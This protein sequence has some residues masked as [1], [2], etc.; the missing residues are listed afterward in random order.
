MPFSTARMHLCMALVAIPLVFLVLLHAHTSQNL[1]HI[2][3]GQAPSFLLGSSSVRCPQLHDTDIPGPSGHV[4]QQCYN[5]PS[6]ARNFALELCHAPRE[7]N[8]FALHIARTDTSQC[9]EMETREGAL[10]ADHTL[11]AMIRA[12]G[13]D[14]FE[15]FTD[16]A[17]RAALTDP[18]YEGACRYRF[19]VSLRNAGP[20]WL[21]GFHTH[22][23]GG[24][25][26]L[27]CLQG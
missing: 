9:A 10:S 23:V 2:L 6:A 17:E 24:V 16:G 20:V 12:G 21:R 5:V 8:A 7:C 13:P 19:D 1:V 27:Q 3:Q 11:N 4:A 26:A 18:V 14:A 22:E 15:L 25:C